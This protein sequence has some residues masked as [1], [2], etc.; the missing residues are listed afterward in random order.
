V[1]LAALGIIGDLLSAQRTITQ[2]VYERVRRIELQLGV[3]PSHYEPGQLDGERGATTGASS[4]RATGKTEE[5]EAVRF[6]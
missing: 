4:G 6:S 5:R 2:R 1:V 3:E